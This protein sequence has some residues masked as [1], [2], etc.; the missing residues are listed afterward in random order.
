MEHENYLQGWLK[1]CPYIHNRQCETELR[2][3][4]LDFPFFT[5]KRME[6]VALSKVKVSRINDDFQPQHVEKDESW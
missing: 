3:E 4:K 6:G 5:M 2:N 1:V